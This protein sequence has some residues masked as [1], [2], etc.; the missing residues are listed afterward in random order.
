VK[1]WNEALLLW[2]QLDEKAKVSRLHHKMANVL[3]AEIGDT[4]K[5]KEHHEK[6]LKILETEPES[7]ELA[8]LYNDVANMMLF[9]I[10]NMA[11]ALLAL[12]K[13]LSLLKN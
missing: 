7:V 1:Y 5:A 4:E 2:K 3:W 10:G 11:K 6:A 8:S 13:R 9:H 12:R